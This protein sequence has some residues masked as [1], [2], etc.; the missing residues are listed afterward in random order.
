MFSNKLTTYI[1]III[2]FLL[3]SGMLLIDIVTINTDHRVLLGSE[4]SKGYSLISA[5]EHTLTYA[6]ESKNGLLTTNSKYMLS[7]VLYE[8]GFK[9]ALVLGKKS[10]QQFQFGA[11]DV[12][13]DQLGL[14]T[15]KA[16]LA[17]RR[18]TSF[19]GTTWGV[20]CKRDRYALISAPLQM[21]GKTVAG[22]GI[23]ID[24]EK[25]YSALRHKQ[26]LILL[27]IVINTTILTFIG[28]YRLAKLTVKPLQ[29]LAE[30]AEK[31]REDEGIFFLREEENNNDFKRLSQALNRMLKRISD[32]KDKLSKTVKSLEITNLDLKKAQE[33][34]IRT[35]KLASIGRLSSGIAHEIGNPI[36][37]I[38]GY[39]ELLKKDDITE[40]ERKDFILRTEKEISRINAIIRQ[41]LDLSRQ[42]DEDLKQVS[43]HGI[44]EELATLFEV[45]PLLSDIDCRLSLAAKEDI[46]KA[47]PGQL[48]QV[49]MNLVINA[50]DAI[51]ASGNKT[52]GTIVIRTENFKIQSSDTAAQKDFLKIKFIDNG[53]GIAT[54]N[55]GNI[56]DPF[57]TTKEPG[58][59]T[60]LGLSV[61]FMLIEKIGGKIAVSSV[62]NQKTVITI[63]LP[64]DN[65]RTQ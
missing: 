24:L 16:I 2:A 31:F 44:I 12:I 63:F 50:A 43:V 41:L 37:I 1:A 19:T 21:D 53:T 39:L 48:R 45:Q 60:G 22:I 7:K 46:V 9:S 27:Y 38:I 40:N 18:I 32:D 56:F 4:I 8:S 59:G 26:Y 23:V 52:N 54:N 5:I 6:N 62:E 28:T 35:E 51:K 13:P 49:F 10:E 65:S 34:I 30:K 61:C 25:I 15:H 42:S 47:D 17:G 33:E 29:S 58:R 3:F 57:F 11:A 14:A 20:L 64:L 55:L 36:S